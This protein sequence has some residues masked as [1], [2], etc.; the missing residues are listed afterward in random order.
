MIGI[1]LIGLSGLKR[2]KK[3]I[4]MADVEKGNMEAECYEKEN[5]L[6]M[7]IEIYETGEKVLISA[8][9][10]LMKM[11]KNLDRTIVVTAAEYKNYLTKIL[12]GNN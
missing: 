12:H 8:N 3:Q 1:G 11:E 9:R 10:K 2:P 5:P 7:E 4:E 6:M